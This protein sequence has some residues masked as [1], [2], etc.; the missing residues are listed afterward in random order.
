MAAKR[1]GGGMYR[2][3]DRP[4]GEIRLSQVVSTYGAGS[5]VDL[6]DSAVLVG[7][8]DYW[9]GKLRPI[10]EPRLR[11]SLAERFKKIGRELSIERAFR[12]PPAGD[13]K[14]PSQTVGIQCL[15]FPRWFVCQ[16]CRSLMRGDQLDFKKSSRRYVHHCGAKS[17]SDAVPVR[18]V[19]ACRKG[20]LQDMPWIW[21]AHRDGQVCASPSLRLTEGPS[22]D[23][24][25]IVVECASCGVPP[26]RLSTFM[27]EETAPECGGHRPWLGETGKQDCDEKMKLLIRTAS[28][29][30]FPQTES[31][32][33]IP[34]PGREVENAV[35]EQWQILQAATESTLPSFRAI[36]AV[37][38]AIGKFSDED[39]L[40]AVEARKSGVPVAREPLRTA[41]YRQFLEAKVERPGELPPRDA[42]FFARR[43]K[44]AEL[45]AGIEQLIL[46][47][48]LREVRTQIGFTRFQS[49]SPDLQGEF[50]MEVEPASLGL[51]TKWL[52]ASEV[53]GEGVLLLFDQATLAGWEKRPAVVK[54]AAELRSG[55]DAEFQGHEHKPPFPGVQF[56]M[57]HSLAH[58]LISAISLECGY[59]ASAIRERIYC[60]D[61]DALPMAGILLSTGTNGTE[62]TLGGLVEQGRRVRSHIRRAYDLGILCSNDPVC[63]SHS[64]HGD[65]AERN[66]EGA[67]CHGCLYIAETSCERWNRYL[68]RALVVPTLGHDEGL[69]F[70]GERP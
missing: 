6:V 24:S 29:A 32:L 42:D 58:L 67:A 18:F 3:F 44:D 69:A 21:L 40:A 61:S 13:D 25:E 38:A 11:D 15:E 68:D 62:G 33:S 46:V 17:P 4:D 26:Q 2:P 57:L 60:S 55:H 53:R 43:A 37:Q 16:G 64:P 52:P 54:R 1:K 10:E 70:F 23:F 36:P 66:L 28:N 22:G 65:M 14:E 41:E 56:Y 27:V 20:H 8:L 48:K 49:I 50:D 47:P 39:V 19:A 9:T 30:Y 12:E 51:E 31:A 7:G 63:A 34:E 35:D 5:V 59:S 45:P